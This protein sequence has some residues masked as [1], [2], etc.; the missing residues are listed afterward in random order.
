MMCLFPEID[1]ES[2]N[3]IEDFWDS[4]SI[5]YSSSVHTLVAYLSHLTVGSTSKD[6]EET[7]DG[8]Q[9]E[10]CMLYGN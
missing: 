2:E 6:C 10:T 9:F 7:D 1:V 8:S 4:D 3:G 5:D